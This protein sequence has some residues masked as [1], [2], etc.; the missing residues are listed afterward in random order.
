MVQLSNYNMT[1]LYQHNDSDDDWIKVKKNS[2][3]ER[4]GLYSLVR[5]HYV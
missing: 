4:I 2:L 1:W 3:T 5:L